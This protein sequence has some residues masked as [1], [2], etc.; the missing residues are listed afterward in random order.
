MKREVVDKFGDE[1]F[2][3]VEVQFDADDEMYQVIVETLQIIFKGF[4]NL[5][6]I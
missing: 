6:V 2:S 4:D 1:N 3:N 5:E